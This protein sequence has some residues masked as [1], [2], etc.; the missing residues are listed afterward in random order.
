MERVIES[1]VGNVEFLKLEKT[2]PLIMNERI[3]KS[4]LFAALLFVSKNKG[5][6]L[7]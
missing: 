4:K 7:K 3:S 5:Y 2:L 1:I 6:L